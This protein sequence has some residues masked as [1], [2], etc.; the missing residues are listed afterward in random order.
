MGCRARCTRCPSRLS[1]YAAASSSKSANRNTTFDSRASIAVSLSRPW[2]VGA[3]RVQKIIRSYPDRV[4]GQAGC[5][6]HSVAGV[7][8]APELTPCTEP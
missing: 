8:T 5:N 7:E 2:S 1:L 4:Y 3:R 6:D